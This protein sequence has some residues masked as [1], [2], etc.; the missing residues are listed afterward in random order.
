VLAL[1]SEPF[2]LAA[3][4]AGSAW[5]RREPL[6]LVSALGPR[7]IGRSLPEELLE[8]WK[9]ALIAADAALFAAAAMKVFAPD[10]LR[11]ARQRLTEEHRWLV[12]QIA[13]SGKDGE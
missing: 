4:V 1:A 13:L 6:R 8:I 12:G 9:R 2:E 3:P 7:L 11:G 5:V 10:E